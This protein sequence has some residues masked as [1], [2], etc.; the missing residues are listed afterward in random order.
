MS[1]AFPP[2]PSP[3]PSVAKGSRA[4]AS[5]AS[6]TAEPWSPTLGTL[7][8]AW[9]T[10]RSIVWPVRLAMGLNPNDS[11]ARSIAAPRSRVWI[12]GRTISMA[13]ARA[14]ED[15]RTSSVHVRVPTS[16]VTAV[17]ARYPSTCVPRSSFT[18]SPRRSA[19]LSLCV[20]VKCAAT[21]LMERHVGNPGFTPSARIRSS[22]L[23]HTS[24]RLA[25]STRSDFPYSRASAAARP[26]CLSFSRTCSST[27][28]PLRR[29][30]TLP[31]YLR[32]VAREVDHRGR[33]PEL[34]WSR[35]EVEGD[36]VAELRARGRDVDRR[37]A[38]L[39]VGARGGDRAEE[40]GEEGRDGVAGDAERDA[41][42]GHQVGR[43]G[44][45][46]RED[47]RV[48][49]GEGRRDEVAGGPPDPGPGLDLAQ[50]GHGD[51]DPLGLGPRLGRDRPFHG[52]GVRGIGAEAVERVGG[53]HDETAGLQRLH[54]ELRVRPV[55]G[56]LAPQ[57]R[58]LRPPGQGRHPRIDSSPSRTWS[59]PSPRAS[60][61]WPGKRSTTSMAASL[62]R[63][64][65][66]W[67]K[68]PVGRSHRPTL[69]PV[70][71]QSADRSERL[72]GSQR[73]TCP[74][75]CP[76]V[77]STSRCASPRSIFCP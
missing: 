39:E 9:S 35:V 8:P 60:G 64:P 42:G 18:R 55:P 67:P 46:G 23:V 65:W 61:P 71:T 10:L 74:A 21:L 56:V 4:A 50:A 6:R 2:P 33:L 32:T 68:S 70:K 15:A 25:P 22:I 76:G 62:R 51:G 73:Q 17:S 34:A 57:P 77:W 26:A 38:S 7:F 19:S 45:R 59:A 75:V 12:L 48:R 44:A 1:P 52:A 20:G 40:P 11:I 37:G 3:A 30:P 43:R 29:N 47:H 36:G 13:A 53:V 72:A 69:P 54:S 31:K 14:V 49:A 5:P 63:E 16:T 66:S 41:Q 28:L 27:R 24:R 58:R